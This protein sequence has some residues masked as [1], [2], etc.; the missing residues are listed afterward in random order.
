MA[1]GL[2]LLAVGV[3]A[4]YGLE[5]ADQVLMDRLAGGR[6]DLVIEPIESP[7][8]PSPP[9]PRVAA[10]SEGPGNAYV[11]RAALMLE[12][13][14]TVGVRIDQHGWIDGEPVKASG[15]YY[16]LGAGGQRQFLL[17]QT[18]QL[19]GFPT[20]LLRVSDS[21]FMWTDLAWGDP[22]QPNRSV[23]RVDLRKVR[24]AVEG[25]EDEED[26]PLSDDPSAW[27]RFGGL[28]MLLAGLD[29]SFTFGQPWLMQFRNER[30]AAMVG[31]WRPE[32]LK[33][34]YGHEEVPPRTPNHVVIAL[35]ETT[36]F[37]VLVE[38][39]DNKDPLSAEG[40]ADKTLLTSSNRPLFKLDLGAPTFDE[41][42][43]SRLFSY[44]PT[45]D[46]WSDQTDREVRLAAQSAG[47]VR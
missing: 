20:R 44:R 17:E 5:L 6:Q 39:R 25:S 11:R 40:L 8:A 14:S 38:Y 4:Y 19:A 32:R 7:P 37:P 23:T 18:G 45:K 21:R 16:Q 41:H 42:L 3:G 22:S 35:S 10:S 2:A 31:R 27:S 9:P 15:Q 46:D 29:E 13:H 33:Q 36:G 12:E 1:R 34:L 30:V 47:V 28:P 26:Q 43:D 24:R